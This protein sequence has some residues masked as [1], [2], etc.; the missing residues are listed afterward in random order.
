MESVLKKI[1]SGKNDSDVH[2]EFIKFS[3]GSFDNRYLIEAKKQKGRWSIKTSA[4]FT[5]FLVRSCL[6]EARGEVEVKGIIVATFDVSSE[7]G[8]EISS[9]KQ[10]MGIKQAVVDSKIH[11]DKIIN[12][13]EKYPKAFFALSFSGAD[14]E[15][16]VKAKAPKN[17]KPSTKGE[18]EIKAD[19][20]SLK[21]S[22]KKIIDDLLFD[23]PIF[24]EIKINHTIQI[25]D[26]ILPKGEKNPVK[27]REDA[28]RKGKIIRKAVVDGKK[29]MKEAEF[30]A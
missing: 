22:N 25:N 4:E 21:T 19:F 12:L 3:R 14:F 7:A 1:F 17:A 6:E 16:K 2:D 30:E 26:I 29:L 5:N 15:L 23:I 24:D 18:S 9:T 27:I 8:F 10:F 11:A 28:V 20:C 13:M